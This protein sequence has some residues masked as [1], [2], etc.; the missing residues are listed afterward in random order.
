MG[1]EAEEKPGH[2]RRKYWPN[3]W[4]L[5]RPSIGQLS[6]LACR[7]PQ[8]SQGITVGTQSVQAYGA[9]EEDPL[10]EGKTCEPGRNVGKQVIQ[11]RMKNSPLMH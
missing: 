6:G 5:A 1:I 10:T 3:V 7:K 4:H 8:T 11:S 9:T 2:A